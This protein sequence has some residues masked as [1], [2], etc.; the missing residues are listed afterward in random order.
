MIS[1]ISFE[2][3]YCYK[4]VDGF[5][6]YAFI[7]CCQKQNMHIENFRQR[8]NIFPKKAFKMKPVKLISS[9]TKNKKKIIFIK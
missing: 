4:L 5:K 6:R 1:H 7:I 2:K 8:I 9:K 3:F